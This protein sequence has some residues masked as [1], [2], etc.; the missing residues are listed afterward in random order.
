M[1]QFQKTAD[2]EIWP[3]SRLKHSHDSKRTRAHGRIRELFGQTV[4]VDGER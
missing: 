1:G 3:P 4:G 2:L